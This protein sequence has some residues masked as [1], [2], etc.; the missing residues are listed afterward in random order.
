MPDPCGR[1]TIGELQRRIVEVCRIVYVGKE[2]NRIEEVD[3][4]VLHDEAE[5][6]NIYQDPRRD[7]W[8]SETP[9]ALKQISTARL[10]KALG[11][12]RRTAKRWKRGEDRPRSRERSKLNELLDG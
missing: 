11:I 4:G 8:I 9:P 3:D 6:L 5:Y 1:L 12:A 7:P 10:T 2:S